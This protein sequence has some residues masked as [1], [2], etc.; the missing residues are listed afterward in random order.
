M[1]MTLVIPDAVFRKAKSRAAERGQ[2]LEDFVTGSIQAALAADAQ[3]GLLQ[4]RPWMTG[5]GGLKR[6]RKETARV[7][8]LT[9]I[10]EAFEAVDDVP[11]P[12]HRAW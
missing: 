4:T 5:F 3:V 10:D 11:G 9:L 6:L 8:A 2:S 1:K 12:R 7:Q